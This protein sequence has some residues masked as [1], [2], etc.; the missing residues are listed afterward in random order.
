MG[1]HRGE[2]AGPGRTCATA[3]PWLARRR[4]VEISPRR[5]RPG[6]RQNE[7]HGWRED[8]AVPGSPTRISV[9][10]VCPGPAHRVGLRT[11]LPEHA[12]LFCTRFEGDTPPSSWVMLPRKCKAAADAVIPSGAHRPPG[13]C[14]EPSK[15][16]L[17]SPGRVHLSGG[18]RRVA[19][20]GTW[21]LWNTGLPCTESQGPG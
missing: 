3:H 10:R 18:G 12:P 20:G 2:H 16:T 7:G 5:Q 21:K 1:A 4:W 6:P 11:P 14:A 17:S 13:P 9:A 19:P 15:A 8:E